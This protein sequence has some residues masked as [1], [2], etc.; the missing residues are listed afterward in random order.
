MLN[1]LKSLG[2]KIE[3]FDNKKKVKISKTKNPKYFASLFFT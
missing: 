1:L 2:S 3:Y